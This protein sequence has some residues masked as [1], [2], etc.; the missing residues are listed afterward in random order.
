ML[1]ILLTPKQHLPLSIIM[2]SY[3]GYTLWHCK[4]VARFWKVL[5]WMLLRSGWWDAT[6]AAMLP[7]W[8]TGTS[9]EKRQNLV[10]HIQLV[11]SLHA[12]LIFFT[13]LLF[14][15]IYWLFYKCSATFI[16]KGRSLR[17]MLVSPFTAVLL[18]HWSNEWEKVFPGSRRT[19]IVHDAQ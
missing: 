7:S 1:C 17:R 8:N 11:D 3:I 12:Y 6:V 5:F 16:Y 4:S 14:L 18:R 15:N 13:C 19:T 2:L 9:E 10:T